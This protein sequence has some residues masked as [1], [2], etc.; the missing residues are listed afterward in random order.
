MRLKKPYRIAWRAFLAALAIGFVL[1][2]RSSIHRRAERRRAEREARDTTTIYNTFDGKIETV[3]FAR[4]FSDLND[5]QMEAAERYGISPLATREEAEARTK[6]LIRIENCAVYVLDSLT[7]SIPYLTPA[8]AT[9]LG[10]IGVA[11]QDSL[12]SKGL[13]PN[14]LIVTSILRTDEDVQRLR[15]RNINASE[16][17]THRYATTFDISYARYYKV[18]TLERHP[19]ESVSPDVL[20]LVFGQVLRD[21]RRAGRCYVKYERKQ[22]CFHIT[23]REWV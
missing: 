1:L 3:P 21:L 20:K 6:D 12:K 14:L 8:A 13:N 9:L 22:A 18:E 11:F 10:D 2:F 7:H 16:N 15:R 23:V 5:L 19:Y 4:L 17:S